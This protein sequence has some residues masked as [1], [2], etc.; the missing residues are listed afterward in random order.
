MADDRPGFD[1][2][3]S[4]KP[5]TALANI[6]QQLEIASSYLLP[7]CL[8]CVHIT[9][10][11]QWLRSCIMHTLELFLLLL[12]SER[13]N[14]EMIKRLLAILMVLAML[15]SVSAVF[16]EAEEAAAEAAA[17]NAA[18]AETQEPVLLVTVN[19]EEILSDDYYLNSV[20]SYY[21]DY[22]S[23]Y[24][25]D[26]TDPEMLATIK[27]Y[28]MEYTIHTKLIRQK[29]AELGL[30]QFTDEEKAAMEADAKADW[31]DIVNSYTEEY[32]A[33]DASDD[34]KAAARADALAALL[35]MGYDE[36]H[37]VS[38]ALLNETEGV[39][40]DRV[41]DYLM[42]GKTI[43]DEDV[44]A[45][46][47]E[48]VK[49]D[50]EMYGNDIATYEF[51]TQY[52]GQPSYYVPEGYRSVVHILL[53]VDDDLLN[54]WKDLSARLEEQQSETETE[55]TDETGG[56][57]AEAT[58]EPVTEEMVSAARQAILDSVQDT[59]NEI[60][61]KLENGVSFEDLIKEY[62]TDPGMQDDATRAKGYYIHKDSI[63]WDSAF[64][65]AAMKLEKI[66]D[67]SAPVVG[68]NGVHILQY[69][70][71]V[72]GGSVELTDE[73]KEEFR[74]SLLEEKKS[75]VLNDAVLRWMEESDIVYTEEGES[76]KVSEEETSEESDTEAE[77]A[78]EE[79]TPEETAAP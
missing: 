77:T 19:G 62:G 60:N 8:H 63:L 3:D 22:A 16:A 53:K 21:M 10:L 9:A 50:Q 44:L 58:A 41:E 42:D 70:K 79:S 6:R 74:L 1:P 38:E 36:E 45:Y 37:Y 17:E 5:H 78:P 2:D 15:L 24:G 46:F 56:T 33:E 72:P 31:A 12:R 40:I 59:V 69:L 34:E 23:Y 76:W 27:Q 20:V 4:S 28:S 14:T 25:Y 39:I 65:D 68:Q 61:A 48:L 64:T 47:E 26:T 67:I 7:N 13:R 35:E 52:Y 75:E 32:A 11:N 51:Y 29:A 55:T 30:D 43:T 57:E 18:E 71:D 49:A 66:G 54:T 73:M